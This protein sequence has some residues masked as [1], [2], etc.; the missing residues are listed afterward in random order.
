MP[1]AESGAQ[2]IAGSINTITRRASPAPVR[3]LVPGTSV[4][5]GSA[6]PRADARLSGRRDALGYGL[7]VSLS[8]TP[9]RVRETFTEATN[10]TTGVYAHSGQSDSRELLDSISLAPRAEYALST[11]S[12]LAV[13]SVMRVRRLTGTA[14]EHILTEA[15]TTALSAQHQQSMDAWCKP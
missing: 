15:G 9:F 8:R 5:H 7:T 13:E 10:G 3:E 4:H 11:T 2:A 1:T 6:Y 14:V 12:S